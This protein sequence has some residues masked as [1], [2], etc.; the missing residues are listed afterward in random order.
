MLTLV[1]CIDVQSLGLNVM[2]M[3]PEQTSQLQG[4]RGLKSPCEARYKG[5]AEETES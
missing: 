3:L 5:L 2:A 4:N 1:Q